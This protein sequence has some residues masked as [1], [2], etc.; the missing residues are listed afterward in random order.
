MPID[1][2]SKPTKFHGKLLEVLSEV[3]RPGIVCTSGDRL[4]TMPGLEVASNV[5]RTSVRYFFFALTELPG[6]GLKSVLRR[7]RSLCGIN[8]KQCLRAFVGRCL[9]LIILASQ[10]AQ[11]EV[12]S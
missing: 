12:V 8:N 4:L 9:P 10:C 1:A 6:N 5:E 2:D 7:T 11:S 3:D